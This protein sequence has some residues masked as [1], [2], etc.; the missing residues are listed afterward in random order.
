VGW[1]PVNIDKDPDEI[2]FVL[3]RDLRLKYH[4][5]GSHL[6]PLC[7]IAKNTT[8][9]FFVKPRLSISNSKCGVKT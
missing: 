8:D 5:T 3:K 6:Q 7:R 1:F 4:P 2:R 9:N